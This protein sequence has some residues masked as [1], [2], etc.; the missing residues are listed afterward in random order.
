MKSCDFRNILNWETVSKIFK[1]I[2]FE[3]QEKVDKKQLNENI[4]GNFQLVRIHK[5]PN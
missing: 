5:L 4:S 2:F 3:T 1:A